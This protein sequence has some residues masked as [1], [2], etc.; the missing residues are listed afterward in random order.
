VGIT[1]AGAAEPDFSLVIVLALQAM[2]IEERLPA[3][4]G[5]GGG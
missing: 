4:H 1:D 2:L 3:Y 5:G